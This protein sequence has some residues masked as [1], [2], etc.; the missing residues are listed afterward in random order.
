MGMRGNYEESYSKYSHRG[1]YIAGVW[2]PDKTRVGW[3]K[4]GYPE[5]FGKVPNSVNYIG[6]KVFIVCIDFLY[7][8]TISLYNKSICY[9]RNNMVISYSHI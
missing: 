4:N 2:Y 8:K 7:E 5:Y 9:L 3:W 6:I 1:S